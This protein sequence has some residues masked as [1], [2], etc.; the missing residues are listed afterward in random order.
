VPGDYQRMGHRQSGWNL[1]QQHGSGSA[2]G[3]HHTVMFTAEG[4]VYRKRCGLC[5]C[6][7]RGMVPGSVALGGSLS[8]HKI[9]RSK[10]NTHI[11]LANAQHTSP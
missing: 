7:K 3:G 6:P 10:H 8:R 2:A 1:T 9:G 5:C 11:P 4:S